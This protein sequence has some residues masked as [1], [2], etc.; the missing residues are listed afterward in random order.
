VA[1]RWGRDRVAAARKKLAAQDVDIRE[2]EGRIWLVSSLSEGLAWID[3]EE[4]TLQ[5][6]G[7]SPL[8]RAW[9]PRSPART[10]PAPAIPFPSNW[11][12]A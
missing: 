2:A 6:F 4:R 5:A 9:K 3:L 10:V 7:Q 8:D 11:F 1:Q 12:G